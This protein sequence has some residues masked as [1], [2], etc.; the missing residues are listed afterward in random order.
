MVGKR[1]FHASG[2]FLWYSEKKE[3]RLWR[4]ARIKVRADQHEDCDCTAK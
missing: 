4:F 2:N 1:S 3:K